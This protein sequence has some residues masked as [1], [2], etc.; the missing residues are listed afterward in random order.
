MRQ[1]MAGLQQH[2]DQ[3]GFTPNIYSPHFSLVSKKP[4]FQLS[5]KG[6]IGNTLDG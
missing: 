3:L 6:N 4:Y 2:L 1:D 5:P